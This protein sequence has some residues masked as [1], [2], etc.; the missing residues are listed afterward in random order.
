MML[1][2]ERD[3]VTHRCSRLKHPP[4]A[5]GTQARQI[6]VWDDAAN[7]D[8]HIIKA[9]FPKQLHDSGTDVIV[10]TRQDGQADHPR[11]FLERR[12]DDLLRRLPKARIDDLHAF[13]T[14]RP[15]NDL[16]ASVV[17]IETRLGNNYADFVH[18]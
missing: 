13:V 14:E 18:V 8:E 5:Q 2:N 16:R 7:H 11:V 1:P 15:A 3:N 4:D 12:L 10:R 9:L 6:D 17:T